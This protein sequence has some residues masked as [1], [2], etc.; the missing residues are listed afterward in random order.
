MKLL[1][2]LKDNPYELTLWIA[3][4]VT[5]TCL[6]GFVILFVRTIIFAH[7]TS[8]LM[9]LILGWVFGR[10]IAMREVIVQLRHFNRAMKELLNQWAV[11]QVSNNP[12]PT[13]PAQTHGA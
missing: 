9:A 10:A 2:T 12:P 7:S 8:S 5:D 3:F 1:N 11:Y 13:Q 6:W 4:E